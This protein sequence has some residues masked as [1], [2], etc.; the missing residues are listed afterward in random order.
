MILLVEDN[1]DDVFILKRLLKKLGRN[2]PIQVVTDG[3][4]ALDYLQ[5]AGQFTD[6]AVYPSPSL[7]FLDLKLPLVH[8]FEVL[9]WIKQHPSLQEIPVAILTSSPEASDLERALSLGAQTFLVKPPT[10]A[11]VSPL[12]LALLTT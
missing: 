12:L 6:R 8:G 9:A 7:I 5:A 10:E 11:T 3:Q 2:L 4:Q 1:E